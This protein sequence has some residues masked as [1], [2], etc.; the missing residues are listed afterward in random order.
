[1]SH[2]EGDVRV[3]SLGTKILG[4][5]LL[6][7]L[8]LAAVGLMNL[9]SLGSLHARV[10]SVN[11]RDLE[12]LTVLRQAQNANHGAVISGFAAAQTNNAAAAKAMNDAVTE[13][14]ATAHKA[15]AQLVQVSPPELRGQAQDIT[16]T[17]NAFRA[18]DAAFKAGAL[19][20]NAKAL[21]EN[22]SNL[23]VSVDSKFE[24]L[25]TAFIKDAESQRAAVTSEYNRALLI[26]SLL[27]ALGLGLGLALG[28]GIRGSVRKR[29]TAVLD[30]L[31]A[32]AKG[33]LTRTAPV[34]G[35]DEIATMATALNT[36]LA[37]FRTT[38]HEVGD[39]ANRL[40]ESA[41]G[42]TRSADETGASVASATSAAGEMS[43]SAEMVTATVGSVASS[44]GELASSIREISSSAQE[45][46]RVAGQ[47]VE[48]VD[49]TNATIAQLG[50]SSEEIG[51]V[52][53]VIQSIAAQ[54]SLLALNATIEAARAGEAGRGFAVVAGEVKDLA[55]E[56]AEATDS[57]ISRVQAIQQDTE[58]AVRAIAEIGEIIQQIN[59]FQSSI[60]AAVEEQS[61]TTDSMGDSIRDALHITQQITAAI[62]G[63]T[64]TSQASVQA[65]ASTRNL[66]EDVAGM[67]EQLRRAVSSFQV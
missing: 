60:A 26:T 9:S 65:V 29:T 19:G 13:Y 17:Y 7:V 2:Q 42:L 39:S 62:E 64:G 51:N 12:P 31:D 28:F 15:L 52:I 18:A 53:Q 37:C 38:L 57:V 32:M 49:S 8:V 3:R 36:G 47:A 46:A 40:V 48:K 10:S 67:G 55:R 23:Y 41:S 14:T 43:T 66:A 20:K 54:T 27:I 33:D 1:M 34:S 35:H 50:N 25:A 45:A 16:N 63:V 21:E 56:T 5:F 6:L 24:A 4:S 30:T 59:Q 61:V 22:A 58:G 11:S 44:T